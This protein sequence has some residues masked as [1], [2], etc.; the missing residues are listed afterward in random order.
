VDVLGPSRKAAAVIA[1]RILAAVAAFTVVYRAE[2][3]PPV[4]GLDDDTREH[5][6]VEGRRQVH[7]LTVPQLLDGVDPVD[8]HFDEATRILRGEVDDDFAALAYG[9]S[10]DDLNFLRR[11]GDQI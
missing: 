11:L 5:A 9:L 3:R 7:G 4:A 10:L 2:S 6:L 8:R 1:R